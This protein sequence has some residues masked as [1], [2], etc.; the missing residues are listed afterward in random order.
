MFWLKGGIEKNNSFYKRANK[1]IRNQN[2]DD[3]IKKHNTINLNWMMK[4]KTNKT[5]TKM[6]RKKIKVKRMRI[7]L[8]NIIFGKLGLKDKIENKWNFYKKSKTKN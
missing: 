3:Q 6:L 8:K 1:K 5:F 4:L 2:N 7:N